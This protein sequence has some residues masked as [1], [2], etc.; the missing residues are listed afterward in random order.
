MRI[1]SR[2]VSRPRRRVQLI[3]ADQ[4]DA[5]YAIVALRVRDAVPSSPKLG[6]GAPLQAKKHA[7]RGLKLSGSE[8]VSEK[9]SP[10]LEGRESHFE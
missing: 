7:S 1:P 10:S 8:K 4:G 9:R 6:E 5:G 2:D 3:R